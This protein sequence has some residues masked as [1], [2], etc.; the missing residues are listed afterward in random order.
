MTLT[1]DEIAYL[2][3]SR[4]VMQK[5]ATFNRLK[6]ARVNTPVIDAA[7]LLNRSRYFEAGAR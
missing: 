7:A 5:L 6:A 2:L 1:D 4:E 3:Q